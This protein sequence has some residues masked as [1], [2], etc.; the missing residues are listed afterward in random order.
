MKKHKAIEFK[1]AKPSEVGPQNIHHHPQNLDDLDI[2]VLGPLM[3]RGGGNGIQVGVRNFKDFV[4]QKGELVR[5]E[6]G[7]DAP[8]YAH[9]AG[10]D[11]AE[12]NQEVVVLDD[13]RK[14]S[15][16]HVVEV[17]GGKPKLS[18]K[19]YANLDGFLTAVLHDM[20]CQQVSQSAV[21]F[22]LTHIIISLDCGNTG[23]AIEWLNQGRRL[24][25]QLDKPLFQKDAQ[26][27]ATSEG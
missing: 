17:P 22:A 7:V 13:G 18:E 11:V 12:D 24:V 27:P 9:I 15:R 19:D 1:V 25:Q 4:P 2:D 14:F 26:P 21:K 3:S 20:R 8:F 23:A 6:T 5:I 16:H 10:F